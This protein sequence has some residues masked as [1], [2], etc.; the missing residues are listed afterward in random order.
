MHIGEVAARTNLS[1]RTIRHY[2]DVDLVVPSGRTQGGFRLYSEAD[3][4]RLRLVRRM[5][6]FFSLEETKELLAVLAAVDADPDDA[7]AADRLRMYREAVLVHLDTLRDQ[8]VQAE[9]FAEELLQAV[10][11]ER[12]AG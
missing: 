5:K 3:V 9:R 6:P 4:D 2:E 10:A 12:D 1:L 7:H 8:V 11:T